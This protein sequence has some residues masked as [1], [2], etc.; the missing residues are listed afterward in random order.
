MA[1]VNSYNLGTAEA[2]IV[3]NTDQFWQAESNARSA[4]TEIE[5]ALNQIVAAVHS[6]LTA[7]S[8]WATR[9]QRKR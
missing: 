3:I 8:R 4:A 9:R 6:I 7:S 2:K 1:G 5:K